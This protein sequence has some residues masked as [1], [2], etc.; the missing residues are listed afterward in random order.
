MTSTVLVDPTLPTDNDRMNE[1]FFDDL[2][3][4]EIQTALA[5]TESSGRIRRPATP[6]SQLESRTTRPAIDSCDSLAA[7]NFER[8]PSSALLC[9]AINTGLARFSLTSHLFK[10]ASVFVDSNDLETLQKIESLR[11]EIQENFSPATRGPIFEKF[12]ERINTRANLIGCA[13]CGMRAFQMGDVKYKV[14]PV[15][16]MK[17]LLLT[18]EQLLELQAIPI[19]YRAAVSAYTANDGKVY[20][21]H[22]ELVQTSDGTN[23][24][25]EIAALCEACDSKVHQNKIPLNSIASGVDFGCAE[26]IDLPKL[27]LV[28]EYVI[29][30]GCVLVSIVKLSGFNSAEKQ[31]GKK[32]HIISFPQPDGAKLL[33]EKT[34][35]FSS[36][37]GGVY[38]N[39]NN[40]YDYIGVT[41]VGLKSQWDAFIATRRPTD[42]N[43]LRV[44]PNV[45]FAWLRA[46]KVLNPLY[47]DIIIDDSQEMTDQLNMIADDLIE[48]ATIVD[49]QRNIMIDRLVTPDA[50]TDLIEDTRS[51]ESEVNAENAAAPVEE[52]VDR[53][54]MQSSFLSCPLIQDQGAS[55]T[56]AF[57]GLAATLSEDDTLPD[58]E[59]VQP[60]P[61]QK[62]S[63]Q[64]THEAAPYNEFENND[65][66]L[67][68]SFPFLFLLGRGLKTSGSLSTSTTRHILLQFTGLFSWCFR[69]IFLLFDQLQRHAASRIV[70]SRVK[71]DPAAFAA[72]ASWINDPD[73]ILKLKAAAANPLAK[74]SIELLK[75]IAP[76]V[77]TCTAK[78]PYSTGQRKASM[79]N[80]YAMIYYYGMPSIFFTFAPDD[81]HGLL[82]L[83]LSI[84]QKNNVNFPATGGAGFAEAI[85]GN[86]PSYCDV[87]VDQRSL[88]QLLADGPVAA[89][90]TFRILT[91][92]IFSV[93]LGTSPAA[94]VK[95]TVPLHM[96]Q[97]GVFGK[98]I[99]SFGCSEEQARGSLHMH[100][101]VW[102]GLPPHLLQIAGGIPLLA[103]AVAKA[104]DSMACAQLDPITHVEN[105]IDKFDSDKKIY[106]PSLVTAKHPI[107]EPGIKLLRMLSYRH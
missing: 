95:R 74:E 55:A 83:R 44:R 67:F 60:A 91:N 31:R 72:F 88:R 48:N 66:L 47:R 101:L 23:G 93:L 97:P 39:V 43:E 45:V 59:D 46:L 98:P 69:L 65:R 51:E 105:L 7:E 37:H 4:D 40:A 87:P 41:F 53:I 96:R 103:N 85:L 78:I 50:A 19:A 16:E 100:V 84:P 3:S 1:D 34:K 14:R 21:L 42:I 81:V 26:R 28:E 18:A 90:E 2:P 35:I 27:S 13:S 25:E 82:N 106:R 77:D 54:P 89:A 17:S 52:N 76:H 107:L 75:K 49:S 99:A 29:A 15:S 102:G 30:R 64:V 62:Q 38:P 86:C 94:S 80:L 24:M 73:F 56:T 11:S 79:I 63:L 61:R 6:R 5:S 36:N 22:P 58:S 12:Q 70:A 92:A 10:E 8:D 33:A 20:H 9:M 71:S 57:L 68:A 32:G 104:L